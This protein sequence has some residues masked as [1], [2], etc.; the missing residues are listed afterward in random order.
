MLDAV[1]KD[2][3]YG[4]RQLRVNPSF[5]LIAVLSLALGIGANTAI[6]Q[7]VNAV[8]LR[9]L[10]V[11]KPQELA[12]I[13]FPPRSMRSG[14]FSTRSARLTFA[15]WEEI[16]KQQQAFS[17]VMAWSA[18]RFTLAPGGEARYAEGLYVSDGFFRVLG[19]APILGRDFTPAD[20]T[21]DCGSPGAVISYSFWQREFLGDPNV[22][23][24]TVL[25]DGRPF[26]VYGVTPA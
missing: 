3:R 6:F 25:L 4:L 23:S 14:N 12:Y 21:P 22:T 18:R 7:L 11:E 16:R 17:S 20:D 10:P 13:D 15:L 9:T 2:L 8:R 26:P 24:R 1:L 5:T 19:I